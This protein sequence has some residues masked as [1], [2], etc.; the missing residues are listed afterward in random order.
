[1]ERRCAAQITSCLAQGRCDTA[2][3]FLRCSYRLLARGPVT[4]KY[5][6]ANNDLSESLV[7][8]LEEQ[9]AATQFKD[10]NPQYHRTFYTQSQL[11]MRLLRCKLFECILAC[12]RVL[13]TSSARKARAVAWCSGLAVQTTR[14]KFLPKALCLQAYDT[15][16]R[17][18]QRPLDAHGVPECFRILAG[19]DEALA[20]GWSWVS[21][22]EDFASFLHSSRAHCFE[23]V[24]QSSLQA[25]TRWTYHTV[26]IVGSDRGQCGIAVKR[27]LVH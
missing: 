25:V 18:L 22:W 4:N 14:A 27:S 9:L 6:S 5:L 26:S 20:P 23:F 3:C 1:M 17:L 12:Q 8:P 19:P 24:L 21:F 10:L 13:P 11:H 2:C 16:N 15:T 7:A